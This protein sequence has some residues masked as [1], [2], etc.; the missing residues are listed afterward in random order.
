MKTSKRWS[1]SG[2]VRPV[3]GE[4]ESSSET[5]FHDIQDTSE[6][7]SFAAAVAFCLP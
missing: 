2:N 1:H 7:C 4:G 6:K 5:D 3:D